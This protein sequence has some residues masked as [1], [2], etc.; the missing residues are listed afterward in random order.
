MDP[1]LFYYHIRWARTIEE[2]GEACPQCRAA[3]AQNG[4]SGL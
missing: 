2:H 4:S 1:Y 3:I